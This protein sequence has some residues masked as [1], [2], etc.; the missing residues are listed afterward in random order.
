MLRKISIS[1]IATIFF[2]A[3]LLIFMLY[4]PIRDLYPEYEAI[5]TIFGLFV[6]SIMGGSFLIL[7]VIVVIALVILIVRRAYYD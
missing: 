3:L 2:V 1:S 4:Y 7:F 6:A 5:F